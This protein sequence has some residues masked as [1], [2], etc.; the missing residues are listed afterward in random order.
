MADNTGDGVTVESGS[1]VTAGASGAG[2]TGEKSASDVIRELK[3]R[4]QDAEAKLAEVA[5]K[6][7]AVRQEQLKAAGKFDEVETALKAKL[8]A[9]EERA[10]ALEAK[11]AEYEK[12][13]TA[14][15]EAQIAALPEAHRDIASALPPDKLAAYVAL[16]GGGKGPEIRPGAPG[17]PSAGQ[18]VT[19]EEIRANSGKPGWLAENWHR[20]GG[21]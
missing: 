13:Q 16:H 19:Q 8:T 15:R 1:G 5:A 3:R 12:Q 10:A 6:E 20:I 9:A 7:E 17:V 14:A 18:R 4:A 21:A 11:A 2:S